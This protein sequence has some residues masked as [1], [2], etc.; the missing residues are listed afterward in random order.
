MSDSYTD[1]T[2]TIDDNGVALFTMNRPDIL[3]ALTDDLKADYVRMLDNVQG[4]DAVKALIITGTGRAFSAGG[5][6]K[7][8]GDPERSKPVGGRSR[9]LQLHDWFE[10]L[11]NLDCPVIAAVD[12]M[13]FG[14][15][16]AVALQA[17]FILASEG[18]K[19]CSVFG[20]IGLVP[21]MAVLYALP[22][23]VGMQKAKELMFTARSITAREAEAMDL[24][25]AI[26]PAQDLLPA[27]H[28][29]AGRLAQG[30]KHA[31]GVTKKIVNRSFQSDY[32][33]MAE[34]EAAAQAILFTTDFHQEAVRRF[35]S[36]ETPLY[37]WDALDTLGD[38]SGDK[39]G[40]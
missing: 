21:D 31:I 20:R 28:A 27:A 17:D 16:L 26:H 36:K 35:Q 39:S 40:D 9:I 33:A 24:L 6:V 2:F 29:L 18:A 14:G 25:Y 1:A 19:F 22:R 11:H 32:G 30:S 8:M 3:N 23:A 5:N 37:N 13:A 12:G 10:R 34:M 4:N 15:G 7:A 38:K